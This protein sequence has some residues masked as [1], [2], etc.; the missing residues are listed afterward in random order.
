MLRKIVSSL[1]C[2][3]CKDQEKS[4][5]EISFDDAEE[6]RICNGALECLTCG[7]WFPIRDYI[8][9]LITL[10]LMDGDTINNFAN[11]MNDQRSSAKLEMDKLGGGKSKSDNP[12][13]YSEQLLQREHFDW[14]A[15]H[16]DAD[17]ADYADMPFWTSVDKVTYE[18]W[19]A[20]IPSKGLF[21]D[22]GCADGRSAMPLIADDRIVIGF[23]ISRAMIAKGLQK[24]VA[25]GAAEK[26]VFF[27]CDGSALPF[28]D[29]VFDC[30]QTYG[31]LHHLP[32]PGNVIHESQRVLKPGG[33]HIGSENNETAFRPVFDW[34]MKIIPLWHE[35]AGE[36]PLISHAMLE[37][38]VKGL[39]LE[40][41]VR[42]T[43]FVPPHLCNLVGKGMANNLVAFTDGLFGH[44]PWIKNNGGLIVFEF[45]KLS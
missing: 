41:S 27:L 30:V 29:N 24:L 43:V 19:N 12:L 45:K 15:D 37:G 22:I 25:D 6:N 3:I 1:R 38:W 34:M 18:N 31:V 35:E 10:D 40:K 26:A 21:L 2:P 28:K 8:L 33:I 7:A 5:K 32:S 44:I 16:P 11:E 36:E 39:N 4:L 13:N 17:Y 23:D 42:T 20:I 9:E 14:Y